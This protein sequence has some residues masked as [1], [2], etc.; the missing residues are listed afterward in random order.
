M[1]YRQRGYQESEYEEANGKIKV[2]P[3]FKPN[4]WLWKVTDDGEVKEG[5]DQIHVQAAKKYGNK[6]VPKFNNKPYKN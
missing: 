4:D 6:W 3:W 5:E 2:K 1:K